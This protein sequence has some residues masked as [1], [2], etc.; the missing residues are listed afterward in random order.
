MKLFAWFKRL[1]GLED[2]EELLEFTQDEV[3][4]PTFPKEEVRPHNYGMDVLQI[5]LR[6][7]DYDWSDPYETKK[8]V[9]VNP[10]DCKDKI[11]VFGMAS[12]W[13]GTGHSEW[14]FLL[15]ALFV[16]AVLNALEKGE[17]TADIT[18]LFN[19]DMLASGGLKFTKEQVYEHLMPVFE[20]KSETDEEVCLKIRIA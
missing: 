13:R 12:V 17:D 7:G 16:D 14:E 2:V 3:V 8:F 20:I 5:A 11:S 15:S 6:S 4:D 9:L 18:H 1:V 10:A 19:R